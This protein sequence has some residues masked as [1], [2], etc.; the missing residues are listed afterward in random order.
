MKLTTKHIIFA[1]MMVL[2]VLAIVMGCLVVSRASGLLQM[3]LNPGG[4]N[5]D[6]TPSSNPAP[7]SSVIP[8]SS[9]QPTEST[10]P[11]VHEFYKDKKVSATCDTGGYT[12]YG[13]S[14]GKSDIR[15]FT[16]PLGHKFG[17][18][19]VVAPTCDKDGWTERTCSRCKKVEITK[20]TAA[21][22][23]FSSWTASGN[24]KQRT[25]SGCDITEIKSQDSAQTWVMRIPA[26][27]QKGEFDV[28]KITV[29]LTSTASDPTY[30]VY[31][32]TTL[33]SVAF[34]YSDAGLV[35]AYGADGSYTA[36]AGTSVLTVN[37]DGTVTF[38]PPTETPAPQPDPS[39]P[40]TSEPGTSEPQPGT[41]EPGTSEPSDE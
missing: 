33:G 21:G 16:D 30:E 9:E 2:L 40:G 36:P 18:Y 17:E 19:K 31:F 37:A 22:H 10:A 8:S 24:T 23:N 12:L 32:N 7:S 29:D 13:C 35:V 14:C 26:K 41:S 38:T 1:L 34:D 11:H 39:E 28:Y 25:C 3:A 4:N 5:T 6:T 15:D 20:P 27:A